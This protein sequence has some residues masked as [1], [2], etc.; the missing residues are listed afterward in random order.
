[1]AHPTIHVQKTKRFKKL[2]TAKYKIK[3]IFQATNHHHKPCSVE[4]PFIV[5]FALLQKPFVGVGKK[6]FLEAN[7]A[8]ASSFGC[9]KC[10]FQRRVTHPPLKMI[11]IG[12]S[13]HGR[14]LQIHVQK[15]KK[16]KKL[17]TTK[18]KRKIIFQATSHHHKSCSVEV[19]FIW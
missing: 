1:M 6:L 5:Y 7:F 4:V 3:I 11:S 12:G 2:K 10:Y 18:E 16:F 17:K 15:I 9:Q 14:P 8:P 13:C 19:P